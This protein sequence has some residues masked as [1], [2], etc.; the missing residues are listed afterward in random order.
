[1]TRFLM[2]MGPV[3]LVLVNS[4][5]GQGS[6][7]YQELLDPEGLLNAPF[8]AG[9]QLSYEVNWKPVFGIPALKAGEISMDVQRSKL[10]GVA[11]YKISAS[12]CSDGT[13]TRVAGFEV[14]NYFESH[15]D[16]K[17]YRSYRIFQKIRQGRRKRD[18]LLTFDYEGNRTLVQETDQSKSPPRTLRDL[19][20]KGIP[21]PA[22]DVLSVFYIARLKK[23]RPG[24]RFQLYLNE[25]GTFKKVFVEAELTERVSTQVGT[26]PAV[27]LTTRGGIFKD[28]GEFRIWYSIDKQRIPVKFEADVKIGKVY[29]SLIRVK[30]PQETR[31]VIRV[32]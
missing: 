16:S 19:A 28:G 30:T 13:L 22:A 18:L 32:E 23:A 17:N 1:M 6:K 29:G 3:L 27:K 20:I 5:S 24:D 11:T 14:R 25:K 4:V 10:E 8:Q 12:A 15:I 9:E 7:N 21:A 31:S 26:F 2:K